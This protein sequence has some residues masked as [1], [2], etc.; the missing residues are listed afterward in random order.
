[1]NKLIFSFT[2]KSIRPR[3]VSFFQIR[4]S[5]AVGDI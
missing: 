3:C 4:L 5:I 1:M 2:F